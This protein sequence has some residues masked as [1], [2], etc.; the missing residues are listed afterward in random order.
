[1]VLDAQPNYVRSPLSS[2]DDPL[3][4]SQWSLPQAGFESAWDIEPGADGLCMAVLDTGIRSDHPD[5]IG[6]LSPGHDFVSDL[7]NS[8]D[9]NGIDSDPTDPFVSLGTHG[10][11]VTGILAAASGNGI[12]V[13]GCTQAG[14]VMPVRVLGQQGGSDFDISQGILYAAGLPNASGLLPPQSAQ[15][16]NMS[17]GG[18][19]SSAILWQAVRDAVA[20][21][22]VVVAAAGNFNSA[23]PMYPA[24]YP[25]VIAV[26]ATDAVDG[27]AYYSSYGDHVDLAA[28][29]G[30]QTADRNGDGVPD[31]VLSTVIDL[32]LGAAYERKTGTSMAAPHVA[33]AAFLLRSLEPSLSVL[34]V[35]A[36]LK[37]GALDLGPAGWDREFG[38]GRLDAGRSLVLAAGLGSGPAEPAATPISLEF[39]QN[40]EVHSFA[41]VNRGGTGPLAVLNVRSDAPWLTPLQTSGS[42]PCTLQARASTDGLPAGLHHT[43]LTL[44]TA[45]GALV[46]PAV[47]SVDGG[48]STGDGTVHV[49]AI[50]TLRGDVVLVLHLSEQSAGEF[51]LDPLAEGTYRIVGVTDLDGDGIGGESDDYSGEVVNPHTGQTELLLRDGTALVGVPLVLETGRSHTLPGGGNIPLGP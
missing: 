29:G 43:Q 1:M 34:E 5:L 42:T 8:G 21:G 36:Y 7:W 20:A 49:L 15:V 41:V 45:A 30:D 9:G 35:A 14:L 44:E 27:R 47:L 10:T 13:A 18:P 25:E 3:Y 39:S 4:A 31:G 37:A 50:D 22:V 46:L 32:S 12:G 33:G 2:P 24:A 17:L 19:N 48:G 26:A 11:H 51:L 16:I 23:Q 40:G 6:R 28:P 38:F